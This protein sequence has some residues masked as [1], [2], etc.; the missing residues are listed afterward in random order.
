MQLAPVYKKAEYVAAVELGGHAGSP[1]SAAN[2]DDQGP[3]A[4]ATGGCTAP[5]PGSMI[6]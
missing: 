2:E 1:G 6:G 4:I 5:N 3:N